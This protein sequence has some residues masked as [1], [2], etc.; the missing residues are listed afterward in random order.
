MYIPAVSGS[1]PAITDLAAMAVAL[2]PIHKG[3][4]VCVCMYVCMYVCIRL[5][6][7]I[8]ISLEPIHK[9]AAVCV[10]V[11]VCMYVCMYKIIGCHTY[12]T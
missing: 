3:A 2:E 5:F 12:S 11:Y 7:A 6:A 9:G 1:A 8:P 10:C 4:A